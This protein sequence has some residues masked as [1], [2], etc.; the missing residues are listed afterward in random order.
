MKLKCT[1][2]FVMEDGDVAFSKGN[3][4][5]IESIE[6]GVLVF[7]SNAGT[8]HYMD[9]DDIENA[10]GEQNEIHMHKK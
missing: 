10:F 9:I 3:T 1:K 4:Y 8:E 6:E 2:D 5:V 7:A